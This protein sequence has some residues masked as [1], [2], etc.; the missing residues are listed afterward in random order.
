MTHSGSAETHR[1]GVACGVTWNT[2]PAQAAAA[3][4]VP[5]ELMKRCYTSSAFRLALALRKPFGPAVQVPY[6][7]AL[8]VADPA[9]THRAPHSNLVRPCANQPRAAFSGGEH[10]HLFP[11][12]SRPT[13][14]SLT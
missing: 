4:A 9:V 14:A 1:A 12:S 8:R 6:M 2:R 3:A 11:S 13:I 7:P 10:F 5:A